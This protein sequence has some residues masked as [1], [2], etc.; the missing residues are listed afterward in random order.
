MTMQHCSWT[1]QKKN[2][3]LGN[4]DF[5]SFK[6]EKDETIVEHSTTKENEAQQSRKDE[7]VNKMK[8]IMKLNFFVVYYT[9]NSHIFTIFIKK[10]KFL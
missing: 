3:V 8:T 5:V 2:H 7:M 10:L 9:K 1:T 4:L 6:E